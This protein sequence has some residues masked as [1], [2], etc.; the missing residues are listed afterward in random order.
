[1]SLSNLIKNIFFNNSILQS[2]CLCEI[3]KIFVLLTKGLNKYL[4]R[5]EKLL[6]TNPHDFV[7]KFSCDSGRKECTVA[8]CHDCITT[9]LSQDAFSKDESSTDF[10]GNESDYSNATTAVVS[11]Y[12]WFREDGKVK[13]CW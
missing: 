10:S 2:T 4:T 1:M 13:G 6:P 12:E 7:E 5:K 11:F 3:C 9:G 8:A